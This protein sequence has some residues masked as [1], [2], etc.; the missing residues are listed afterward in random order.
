MTIKRVIINAVYALLLSGTL[1]YSVP[2]QQTAHA[3]YYSVPSWAPDG[4]TIAFESNRDGEAAVYTIRPDGSG[5]TRLTPS[6]SLGEQPNW[7]PDGRHIVF[8]SNRGGARQLYLMKPDGSDVVALPGT[9]NGFLAA[10]S[11]DGRWLL[12]AAQDKRPSSQY[13]VFVMH[14]DGSNRRQLGDSTKS[15][16]DPRWTIDGQRV[17]FTEVPMLERLPNEA[18]KEFVRRRTKVQQLFSITPD[19][20]VAR[21]L[22][23]EEG[24]RM[25]R[26]RG[27][28]PDGKWLVH[29]KQV[30]GVTGLYLQEQPSG[31]ERL[32]DRGNRKP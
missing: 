21:A 13:R 23:P 24:N 5:L 6:G 2:A 27:L 8:A 1:T 12:F 30:E 25:T 17:V 16:E 29:S 15:N 26:D 14:P 10:F 32:L 31:T 19:G 3:V 28:S 9:T 11:P 18:P 4:R 7:S 20:L 22:Q